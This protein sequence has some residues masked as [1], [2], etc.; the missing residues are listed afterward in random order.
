LDWQCIRYPAFLPGLVE[1]AKNGK[2]QA[3]QGIASIR[4]V[5]ATRALADLLSQQDLA[6]ASKA[7]ALIEARLPHSPNE[8]QG[9]WGEQKRQF[10]IEGAWNKE[11][12]LPVRDFCLRL[13]ASETRENFKVAT[14]LLGHIGAKREVPALLKALEFALAQM[15]PEYLADIHYPSPIRVCDLL[16]SAAMT[17]DPKL[18]IAPDRIQSP[19]QALLYVAKRAGSQRVLSSEEET[20]LAEFSRHPLP[21]IR[22]KV[23][24]SLPKEIPSALKECITARMT[25]S[26]P[27]VRGFA[28]E[29]AR[30]MQEP[31]HR[32]IALAV[33]KSADDEWLRW[34]AH[35][36]ALK[37]GARYECALAWCSH[38]ILPKVINDYTT[39]D[40]LR[41]LFE[42]T[43]SHG[44]NGG[45]N[46]LINAASAQALRERWEKFL[47]ANEQ[48]IK[49]GHVFKLG[50][51][52]PSNLLPDGFS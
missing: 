45:F 8:F 38:L 17:I 2:E 21:Y 51:D 44:V 18:D 5:E 33:L 14:S 11:L 52:M 46:P 4:T 36:I 23:I 1:R 3:L 49:A 48:K 30:R 43:V 16:L 20:K 7:A 25:D 24:E 19:G 27:G 10:I 42:L 13:L 35:D 26:N 12:D 50:E 34:S 15:S 31:K 37:Y 29:A 22:M 40:A 41:H 39:H 9:S 32:E 28:F 6:F 47:A